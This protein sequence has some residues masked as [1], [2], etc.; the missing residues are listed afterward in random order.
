VHDP[1]VPSRHLPLGLTPPTRPDQTM[2]FLLLNLLAVLGII[3]SMLVI[4]ATSPVASVMYLIA[5]FMSSAGYLV[6][7]GLGF[8]GLAYLIVYIGAV[9]VLFLF[10]VML[11][12]VRVNE[13]VSVGIEYTRNLPLGL[14]VGVLFLFELLSVLPNVSAQAGSVSLGLFGLLNYQLL[15]ISPD[16]LTVGDAVNET[17]PMVTPEAQFTSFSQLEMLGQGLYT[18]NTM[19]LLVTS[20]LLL[21]AMMGPIVLCLREAKSS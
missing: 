20:L 19:W 11:L 18:Y 14:L 21:L 1:Q 2:T 12:S 8:V 9:A 5:V 13:L 17:F 15:G 4:T 6:L 7:L 3:F 16:P 10:V